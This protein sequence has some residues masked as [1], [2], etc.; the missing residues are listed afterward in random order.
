[1]QG[2]NVGVVQTGRAHA[3]VYVCVTLCYGN[4]AEHGVWRGCVCDLSARHNRTIVLCDAVAVI[5]GLGCSTWW[6]AWFR[7]LVRGRAA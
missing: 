1:M 6:Q 3:S 5:T 4:Y 2:T 7:W